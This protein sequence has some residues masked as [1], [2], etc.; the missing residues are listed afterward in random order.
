MWVLNN[1]KRLIAITVLALALPAFGQL[2]TNL[3]ATLMQIWSGVDPAIRADILTTLAAQNKA[4]NKSVEWQGITTN[5]VYD[6]T[7]TNVVGSVVTTNHVRLTL[8]DWLQTALQNE[9]IGRVLRTQCDAL[10]ADLYNVVGRK[11]VN[12]W[13]E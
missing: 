1:M 8:S 5:A 9:K 2:N 7:G 4:V 3:N 11:T 10:R 12:D 13:T 6:A